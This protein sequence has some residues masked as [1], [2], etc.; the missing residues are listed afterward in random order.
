MSL[1]C[2]LGV[3]F[4]V[5]FF[6]CNGLKNMISFRSEVSDQLQKFVIDYLSGND[7]EPAPKKQCLSPEYLGKTIING[8]EDLFK[9]LNLIEIDAEQFNRRI[10]ALPSTTDDKKKINALMAKILLCKI[11]PQKNKAAIDYLITNRPD[12]FQAEKINYIYNIL[13]RLPEP[14]R[15]V[16]TV[17]TMLLWIENMEEETTE[18]LNQKAEVLI[19]AAPLLLDLDIVSVNHMLDVLKEMHAFPSQEREDIILAMAPLLPVVLNGYQRAAILKEARAFPPEQRKE[20]LENLVPL[21][22]EIKCGWQLGGILKNVREFPTQQMDELTKIAAPLLQGITHLYK[23][24]MILEVIRN[25]APDQRVDMIK[26][27]SP[28]IQRISSFSRRERF[29]EEVKNLPF[30]S[31]EK[32]LKEISLLNIT[33]ET[34]IIR[35]QR[36]LERETILKGLKAEESKKALNSIIES[37]EGFEWITEQFILNNMFTELYIYAL[38]N[39]TDKHGFDSPKFIEVWNNIKEGKKRGDILAQVIRKGDQK[40]LEK[41][42]KIPEDLNFR[43]SLQNTLLI[44]AAYYGHKEIVQFLLEKGADPHNGLQAA[45]LCTMP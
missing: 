4:V 17:Q 3:F 23:R 8:L 41:L 1:L 16:T 40:L 31:I 34:K 19:Q 13:D 28:L 18:S 35:E 42:L 43:D 29:L 39:F 30:G 25:F 33:D 45:V 5:N 20:A 27:V 26:L 9:N 44:N 15:H 38:F 10:A 7:L 14:L 24:I 21:F 6:T 12:S 37:E 36:T 32:I 2:A 22:T 11:C